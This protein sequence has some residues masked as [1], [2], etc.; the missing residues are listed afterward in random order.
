MLY[1]FHT[2]Q[3]KI[4]T[5]SNQWLRWWWWKWTWTWWKYVV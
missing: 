3:Y 5:T 2:R 4:A 1:V